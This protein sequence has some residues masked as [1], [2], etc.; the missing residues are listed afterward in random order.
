MK[1]NLQAAAIAL[2]ILAGISL[3]AWL[4]TGIPACLSR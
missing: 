3:G 2:A 1:T 4:I